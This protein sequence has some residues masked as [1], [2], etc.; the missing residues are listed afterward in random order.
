MGIEFI[1]GAFNL[2][3]YR[4]MSETSTHDNC[5]FIQAN[6][7]PVAEYKDLRL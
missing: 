5:I 6:Y 7:V 4:P 3:M 2:N 1:L